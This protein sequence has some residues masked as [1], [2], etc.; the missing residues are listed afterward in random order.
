MFEGNLCGP[1]QGHVMKSGLTGLG[2]ASRGHRL[3]PRWRQNSRHG[4]GVSMEGFGGAYLALLL[5]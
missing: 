2:M 4:S 5:S 3:Y 1:Q